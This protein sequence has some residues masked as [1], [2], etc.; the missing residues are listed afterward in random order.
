MAGVFKKGLSM[1]HPFSV[2]GKIWLISLFCAAA[3]HAED[4]GPKIS[5]KL[6]EE[7]SS[8]TDSA[9]F[10]TRIVLDASR[11]GEISKTEKRPLLV[12]TEH[13]MATYDLKSI[14]KTDSPYTP[15]IISI[16]PSIHSV[17]YH[18]VNVTKAEILEIISEPYILI[19]E[20]GCNGK[21]MHDLC[22]D[23]NEKDDTE[24]ISFRIIFQDSLSRDS[25]RLEEYLNGLSLYHPKDVSEKLSTE[26]AL[27]SGLNGYSSTVGDLKRISWDPESRFLESWF[28]RGP[29]QLTRVN[30]HRPGIRNGKVFLVNGRSLG[31]SP[32]PGSTNMT[33]KSYTSRQIR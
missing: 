25:T 32:V 31:S 12:W 6:C 17:M 7:I 2:S 15:E 13:L 3:I 24:K 22:T 4:C 20:Q 21:I 16:S 11:E 8:G 33:G 9:Y 10:R 26:E 5:A 28:E 18:N 27:A 19:V 29:L 30:R 14:E 1:F 23:M